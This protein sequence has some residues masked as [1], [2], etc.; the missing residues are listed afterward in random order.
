MSTFW[1]SVCECVGFPRGSVVRS[2]PAK[3]GNTGSIPGLGRCPGDGNGDPLQYSCLENSMDRGARGLQSMGSEKL[4]HVETKQ[5]QQ[6]SEH[7]SLDVVAISVCEC[8]HLFICRVKMCAGC[9]VMSVQ[10]CVHV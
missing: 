2:P 10:I 9:G 7:T 8:V 5:Q 6:Q 3:A 4:R 1:M